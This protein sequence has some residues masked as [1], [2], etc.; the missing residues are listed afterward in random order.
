MGTREQAR[1]CTIFAQPERFSCR[2]A[3]LWLQLKLALFQNLEV[4]IEVGERLLKAESLKESTV[5]G[6][7]HMLSESERNGE[8]SG[9]QFY[10]YEYVVTTTLGE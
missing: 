6:G 2:L 7:V 4:S 9:I 8:I 5:P 3:S 1:C 10:D